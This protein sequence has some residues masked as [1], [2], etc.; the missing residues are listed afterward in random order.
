MDGIYLPKKGT[1]PDG[2]FSNLDLPP[3]NLDGALT[4]LEL[5]HR[6]SGFIKDDL[7]EVERYTFKHPDDPTLQ[8]RIQYNPKRAKRFEGSGVQTPP[9][10]LKIVNNGCFLCRENIGWQQKNTQFGLTVTLADDIYYA[11]MNPFPLMPNHLVVADDTHISQEWEVIEGKNGRRGL[12]RLL[13]D[14]CK[15]ATLL[16]NHVG[17]Y[18]GVGAGASIPTHLHFQFFRRLATDPVFPLESRL[19]KTPAKKDK[20]EF[21]VNYPVNVARWRGHPSDVVK[22]AETWIRQWV[23]RNKHRQEILSSNFIATTSGPNEYISLYFIPRDRTKARFT[24]LSGLIGGLEVLGELVFSSEED[25][26]LLDCGKVDYF[27]CERS[28]KDAHTPFFQT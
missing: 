18:N 17:F 16:P 5:H 28:L 11:L 19:F 24:H 8:L 4:E 3:G 12:L 10:N 1:E 20:P 6:K 15:T 2:W 13:T 9:P 7:A 21:V 23:R 22:N 25:K 14:L 26:K 27:F